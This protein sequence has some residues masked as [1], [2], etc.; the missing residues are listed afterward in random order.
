MSDEFDFEMPD[1]GEIFNQLSEGMKGMEEAMQGMED[2]L[3]D[4][5]E[6]MQ[7][8]PDMAGILSAF[9]G[10]SKNL[11]GQMGDLE[12][13]LGGFGEL[14]EENLNNLAGKSD[15]A[16]N[17]NIQIGKILKL[18]VKAVFDLQNAL[19]TYQST[20]GSQM[21]EAINSVL[22]NIAD[23]D[24]DS[25]LGDMIK[26]ELKQGR[27]AASVESI[28]VLSC[29]IAGAPANS[30]ENLKLSPEAG[31]PIAVQEKGISF[32]F[33]PMLTIKNRW[34]NAAIPVF[35]PMGE[36][37]IVPIHKFDQA[38][39]FKET[40]QIDQEKQ[41]ILISIDFQLLEKE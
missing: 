35:V 34:E 15:W 12:E 31:I 39:P 17:A 26:E 22:G 37:V 18:N 9:S 4:V 29:T 24:A 21:D 2:A 32:E 28:Q 33:A 19:Q 16:I 7:E 38:V 27:S 6:T 10:L 40:F 5:Q 25:E 13:A 3:E 14:H 11:P 36:A 30:A 41:T 23:I 20:Q 8:I 1:M